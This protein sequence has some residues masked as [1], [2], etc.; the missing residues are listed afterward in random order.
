LGK[1]G[2]KKA[3]SVLVR[4][5]QFDEQRN[6]FS[7]EGQN[8]MYRYRTT[9]KIPIEIQDNVRLWLEIQPHFAGLPVTVE[10]RDKYDD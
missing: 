3:K 10:L 9:A 1:K 7:G 8:T 5:D 4:C 6:E 2:K